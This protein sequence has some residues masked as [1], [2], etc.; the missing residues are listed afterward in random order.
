MLK[1]VFLIITV[2]CALGASAQTVM[3]DGK[4]LR[5][6]FNLNAGINSDGYQLDA[7]I[8]Y[9]PGDCFGLRF[10]FALN[11]EIGAFDDCDCWS[12]P[13]NYTMRVRFTPALVLRTPRIIPFR[14]PDS[15]LTMFVEPGVTFSPGA[16]ESKDARTVCWDVKAG[17]NF[18]FGIGFFVLGYECTNFSLYSGRPYSHYVQ[19]DETDRITHAVYAGFGIKF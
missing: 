1:R 11:G 9:F 15:G 17:F 6:E 2:L 10:S 8:G 12:N 13:D 18:Q 19:P 5:G 16:S 3:V 4:L 7:G 14:E